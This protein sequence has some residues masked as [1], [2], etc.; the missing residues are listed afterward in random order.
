MH[1]E[2]FTEEPSTEAALQNLLPRLL[3]TGVTFGTHLFQGKNDLLDK[4]PN[5]LRAYR[6][7]H[8]QQLRVIVIVDLDNDDCHDL[9]GRLEHAARQAG[10]PTKS[11]AGAEGMFLVMNRIVIEELEAW[12]FGDPEAVRAA[13]PRMPAHFEYK[14]W[15][16]NPD[17][18]S[19]GTKEAFH[20]LLRRAGYYGAYVP[21]IEVA[22]SISAH[23][24]PDRNRSHSFRVF[25]D[26][27]AALFH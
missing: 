4:L 13:Y 12:F 2:V 17:A 24:D 21:S 10:L 20:R 9:K 3:P 6:G 18:V 8:P 16:R 5:R 19:G 1:L 11:T 15:Y 14:A 26:G 27:V 22:R 23:M 7:V 25:C